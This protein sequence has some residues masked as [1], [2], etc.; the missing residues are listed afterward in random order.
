[1]C[2]STLLIQF[3]FVGFRTGFPLFFPRAR[4]LLNFLLLCPFGSQLLGIRLFRDTL[5]ALQ[6]LGLSH[7]LDAQLRS[8]VHCLGGL[9]LGVMGITIVFPA[10]GLE[11]F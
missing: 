11:G 3:A 1:M 6:V 7:I 8:L 5:V 10:I 9:G 2:F 4:I